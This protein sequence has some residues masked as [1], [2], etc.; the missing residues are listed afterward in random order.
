MTARRARLAAEAKVNLG[1]RV[2][3]R[4]PSGYH[5]LETLFARIDLADEIVVER[6]AAGCT[7]DV[8][9]ADV[10]PMERN[11]AYRRPSPTWRR[12]AGRPDSRSR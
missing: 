5:R 2:L 4:E 10:G 6:T 11:L 8:Q 1:L 3:D 9:G 12:A 7:L